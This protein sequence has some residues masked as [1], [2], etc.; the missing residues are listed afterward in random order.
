M[1]GDKGKTWMVANIDQQNDIDPPRHYSWTLWS[2]KVP[3]SS[4]S[5]TVC[6]KLYLKQVISFYMLLSVNIKCHLAIKYFQYFL[7]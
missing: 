4:K 3:V 5:K 6:I 7:L 1:T 2:A